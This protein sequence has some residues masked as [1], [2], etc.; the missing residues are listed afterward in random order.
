MCC[1]RRCHHIEKYIAS[2]VFIFLPLVFC[3]IYPLTVSRQY[4]NNIYSN[5]LQT[6][7]GGCQL[8]QNK[9]TFCNQYRCC[10][11]GLGL[12]DVRGD[13]C[14]LVSEGTISSPRPKFW[15]GRFSSF[16]GA[17][18]PG[19]TGYSEDD[20]SYV[21]ESICATYNVSLALSTE[22]M[23]MLEE[24]IQSQ[25]LTGWVMEENQLS[26]KNISTNVLMLNHETGQVTLPLGTVFT[27][28]RQRT[29][30]DQLYRMHPG[31]SAGN[32]SPLQ[33]LDLDSGESIGP[34]IF[35]SFMYTVNVIDVKQKTYNDCK[36]VFES[37]FKGK[38]VFEKD[39]QSDAYNCYT[40]EVW[41]DEK[42]KWCCEN[43]RLGCARNGKFFGKYFQ[44]LLAPSAQLDNFDFLT[45]VGEKLML[46]MGGIFGL[47]Y[48][49]LTCFTCFHGGCDDQQTDQSR[50]SPGFQLTDIEGGGQEHKKLDD[51]VNEM[52]KMRAAREEKR[53]KELMAMRTDTVSLAP[54]N[55]DLSPPLPQSL[56]PPLL[57]ISE[58]EE[59][60][61]RD[62]IRF[63]K[64][65]SSLAEET[66]R[67]LQEDE[68]ANEKE[69]EDR[70][71]LFRK[72]RKNNKKKKLR[73]VSM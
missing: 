39:L 4:Y 29:N 55:A 73:N 47:L 44:V 61:K 19:V 50:R 68:K 67:H 26:Y 46:L 7:T 6:P 63:A 62:T 12:H 11:L 23:N 57:E 66:T 48:L 33:I 58:Q 54:P 65:I 36:Y 42:R 20:C 38:N 16:E 51:E 64:E 31:A 17:V 14:H 56:S 37:T 32:G 8:V 34:Y 49:I 5:S 72:N 28:R 27:S 40:R 35:Q 1:Q 18:L 43:K 53:K 21:G 15:Q 10:N 69:R 41:Q 22:Q 13:E 60:R 45:G 3:F 52:E 59:E 24:D 9:Q 25:L 71:A 2:F 70:K 30:P